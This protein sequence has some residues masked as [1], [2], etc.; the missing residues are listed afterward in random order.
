[1][2]G[3]RARRVEATATRAAGQTVRPPLLTE[4][5]VAFD[6]GQASLVFDGATR[7]GARDSTAVIGTSRV[8][9]SAGPDLNTQAVE[10]HTGAGLARPVL[11][12]A[13]FNDGFAGAMGELLCALE[14]RRKPLNS[15]RANLATI[16]LC[17]AAIRSAHSAR[18]VRL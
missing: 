1:M 8:A 14:D 9:A 12:G 10:L 7:Y 17:Q 5:L 15:A 2:I 4:V 11:D 6:G 18:P 13:W 3:D 16:K